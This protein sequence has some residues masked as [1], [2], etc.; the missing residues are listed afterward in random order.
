MA[1]NSRNFYI[2]K[3]KI[4]DDYGY[5]HGYDEYL[6]DQGIY[7]TI[8]NHKERYTA[9][10]ER[11]YNKKDESFENKIFDLKDMKKYAGK[12]QKGQ[13]S[14]VNMDAGNVEKG[15]KA[16]NNSMGAGADADTGEGIGESMI[17]R[18]SIRDFIGNKNEG[19][20]KAGTTKD[21]DD[22]LRE[23]KLLGFTTEV[24]ATS[25]S[26]FRIDYYKKLNEEVETSFTVI[27]GP[28]EEEVDVEVF[29]DNIK[30]REF[31]KSLPENH[32]VEIIRN[33][34]SDD[35]D[36]S[37][38]TIDNLNESFEDEH[39]GGSSKFYNIYFKV[40]NETTGTDYSV[41]EEKDVDGAIDL[42]IK[43]LKTKYRKHFKKDNKGFDL[44]VE[45]RL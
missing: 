6:T 19:S 40:G 8:G 29:M 36:T 30:A 44:E 3:I 21:R 2:K 45:L 9:E 12:R 39:L 1:H 43:D 7:D 13:G 37:E 35:G 28:N 34:V 14:F 4:L 42:L 38:E 26:T 20:I 17:T 23:L 27:H 18:Q 15:I 32:Y 25:S 41:F 11:L 16:F 10:L 5:Q 33:K 31:V 24:S 22:L